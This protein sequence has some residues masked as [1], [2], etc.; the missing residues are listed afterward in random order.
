M[1]NDIIRKLKYVLLK[2]KT[3]DFWHKTGLCGV[4]D[5]TRK[6]SGLK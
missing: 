5:W 3:A 4:C 2:L 1:F 6:I